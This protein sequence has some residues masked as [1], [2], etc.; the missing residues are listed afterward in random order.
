M[1]FS[2]N[3]NSALKVPSIV[4]TWSIMASLIDLEPALF[5]LT[6]KADFH[7]NGELD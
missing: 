3:S 6:L 7:R 4:Q 5:E 2:L 1:N